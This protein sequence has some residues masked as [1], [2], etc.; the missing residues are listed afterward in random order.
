L[1][2][3]Q[4]YPKG[5]KNFERAAPVRGKKGEGDNQLIKKS[6]PPR[7][8]QFPP[9]R[10]ENALHVKKGGGTKKG[11]PITH[12]KSQVGGKKKGEKGPHQPPKKGKGESHP[13]SEKKN[14]ADGSQLTA[15]T[16]E[17]FKNPK[18]GKGGVSP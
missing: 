15:K 6:P 10:R 17:M 7:Q 16:L 12:Q 1:G 8:D 18:R 2:Q 4:S 14:T 5:K 3:G 13:L 11:K 9:K